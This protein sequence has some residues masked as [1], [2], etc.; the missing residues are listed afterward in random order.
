MPKHYIIYLYSIILHYIILYFF[1][2]PWYIATCT[3]YAYQTAQSAV[4]CTGHLWISNRLR[5]IQRAQNNMYSTQRCNLQWSS[6]PMNHT[7]YQKSLHDKMQC[8]ANCTCLCLA[9]WQ[10]SLT[11][12]GPPLFRMLSLLQ[13]AMPT[14]TPTPLT[15]RRPMSL[16]ADGQECTP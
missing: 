14:W 3:V 4:R 2:L 15:A 7:E 1:T 10:N 9:M 13:S 11:W 16:A 5:D 6:R 12:T 8:Y